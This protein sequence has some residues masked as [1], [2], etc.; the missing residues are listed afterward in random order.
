MKNL[1]ILLLTLM[2]LLLCS[3]HPAQAGGDPL[4]VVFAPLKAVDTVLHCVPW[5]D[6]GCTPYHRQFKKKAHGGVSYRGGKRVY[7]SAYNAP[8][9]IRAYNM[10]KTIK[11]KKVW[12]SN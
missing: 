6:G 9:A 3:G 12:K 8:Q 11:P 10:P 2:F 5:P 4:D 1:R 7:P